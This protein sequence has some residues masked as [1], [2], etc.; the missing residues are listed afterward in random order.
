M[1]GDGRARSTSGDIQIHAVQG[2][3]VVD[4]A[5]GDVRLDRVGDD[6]TVTTASGDVEVDYAAAGVEV[7]TTSGDLTVRHIDGDDVRVKTMSG[8]WRFCTAPCRTLEVDVQTLS[9]EVRNRL[10]AGDG[11]PPEKRVGIW[12]KTLSGD[13]TLQ[14]I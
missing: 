9:G 8:D 7:K 13:I 14:G 1:V 4:S 10:P 3:L 11:S 12:A 6:L 5:S 2:R